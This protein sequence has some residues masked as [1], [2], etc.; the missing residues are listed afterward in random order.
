MLPRQQD[1]YTGARKICYLK[2]IH[3]YMCEKNML[4]IQQ[5]IYIGVRKICYLDNK[6]LI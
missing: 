6:T 2:T 3:L 5:D 4:P 1:I